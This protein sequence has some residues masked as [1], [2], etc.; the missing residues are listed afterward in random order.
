[1]KPRFCYSRCLW[2]LSL[3]FVQRP[4]AYLC[5]VVARSLIK[6]PVLPLRFGQ[7]LHLETKSGTPDLAEHPDLPNPLNNTNIV[8]LRG[9]HDA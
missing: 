7:Y 8:Q 2:G 5:K 1:M 6:T 9:R 4:T 3:R